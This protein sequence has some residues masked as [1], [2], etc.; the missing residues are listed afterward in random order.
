VPQEQPQL[1][2]VADES[3]TKVSESAR[4]QFRRLF[5]SHDLESASPTGTRGTTAGAPKSRMPR[6][7]GSRSGERWTVRAISA[8]RYAAEIS[9]RIDYKRKVLRDYGHIRLMT[10]WR[11][12]DDPNLIGYPRQHLN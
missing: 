7:S 6:S 1:P 11:T 4:V 5:P 10:L 3:V 2:L 12:V 8:L 9:S